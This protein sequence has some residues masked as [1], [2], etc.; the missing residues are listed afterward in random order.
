LHL[1][2]VRDPFVSKKYSA[3]PRDWMNGVG[4]AKGPMTSQ[5]PFEQPIKILF[6]SKDA[7]KGGG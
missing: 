5:L 7:E 1:E 6:A 3:F 4:L 2:L